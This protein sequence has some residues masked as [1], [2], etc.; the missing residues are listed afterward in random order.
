MDNYIKN[1]LSFLTD[2]S[3]SFSRRSLLLGSII[4]TVVLMNDIFG[5]TFNYRMNQKISQVKNLYDLYPK[6][7]IDT[8]RL[9]KNLTDIEKEIIEREPITS[10]ITTIYNGIIENKLSPEQR[11]F[12]KRL[13]S[14]LIAFILISLVFP[15]S[16]KGDDLKTI[17]IGTAFIALMANILLFLIPT[18]ENLFFNHLINVVSTVALLILLGIYGSKE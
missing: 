14:G 6:D 13:F 1:F 11:I 8:T 5:F 10:T 17:Y 15:F 16:N 12:I 2:K 9:I 18:F 4:F 3:V 7:K